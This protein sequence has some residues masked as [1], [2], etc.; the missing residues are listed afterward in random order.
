MTGDE[1]IDAPKFRQASSW[2][3]AVGLKNVFI[4]QKF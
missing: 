1:N 3:G 4:E 2:G